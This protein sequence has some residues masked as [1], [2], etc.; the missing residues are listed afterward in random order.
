MLIVLLGG[1]RSGK[2]S[3]A[4][5]LAREQ[6]APVVFLATGEPDLPFALCWANEPWSRRWD[7][8]EDLVLQEQRYSREDDLAHIR[9]LL[10]ALADPRALGER[11]QSL[12]DEDRSSEL[13]RALGRSSRDLVAQ[14]LRVHQGDDIPLPEPIPCLQHVLG[15]LAEGWIEDHQVVDTGALER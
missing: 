15:A 8:S 13:E 12:P 9:A 4:Q 6:D 5:R 2:S 1:A 7:G 11:A 10:P 3:L 14:G